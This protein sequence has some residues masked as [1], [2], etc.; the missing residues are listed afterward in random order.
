MSVFI[1]KRVY[2]PYLFSEKHQQGGDSLAV[3]R[4]PTLYIFYFISCPSHF[5][6][7]ADP[8]IMGLDDK[9]T[10]GRIIYLLDG[11]A[12]QQILPL[13]TVAM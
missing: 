1:R 4:L 11:A 2:L 5:H 13:P 7:V 9:R 12:N 8:Y 3:V 6:N 10:G